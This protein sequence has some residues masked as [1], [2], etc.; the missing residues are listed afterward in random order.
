[1]D[2]FEVYQKRL[3]ANGTDV[4]DSLRKNTHYFKDKKFKASTTYRRSK[5]YTNMGTDKEYF[6][7]EDIRI[8]EI[9][10]QG[11]LRNILFKPTVLHKVGNIIEFDGDRWLA[12]DT[13]GSTVD[14]IKLRVSKINDTLR[15]KDTSGKIIDIPSVTSTSYLGSGSKA[16]DA[17][18]GY[19][20]FDVKTPVGKILIAVELNE[21]TTTLRLGQR[22]ICGSKVYKLEHVDDISYVDS[23]YYGV[24]QL[25]LKE[26]IRNDLKDDFE[27]GIAYQDIWNEK[28]EPEDDGGGW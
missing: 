5:I 8:N 9:D 25:T 18:L 20:V 10:R 17:G 13:F 4:G 22:F 24:L 11:T 2:Y 21:L 6:V 3:E 23:D 15:W 12:Y 27:T 16:N 19:N 28:D 7:E 14:D 26:D 1:M